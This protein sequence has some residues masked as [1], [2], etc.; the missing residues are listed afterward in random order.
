MW[1]NQPVTLLTPPRAEQNVTH[2]VFANWMKL[3]ILA[4]EIYGVKTKN[5]A[6]MCSPF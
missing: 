4:S 3:P 2:R 1:L 6:T 5:P